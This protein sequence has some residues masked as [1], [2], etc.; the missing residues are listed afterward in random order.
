MKPIIVGD[1]PN[2]QTVTKWRWVCSHPDG[3]L[4][5]TLLDYSI[6]EMHDSGMTPV[7]RIATTEKEVKV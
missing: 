2:P 5:L 6:N 4:Y 7:Q 1:D 3:E